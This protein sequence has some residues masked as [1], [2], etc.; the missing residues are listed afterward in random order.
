[1]HI[2]VT[3]NLLKVYQLL[4]VL[5][6]LGAWIDTTFRSWVTNAFCPRT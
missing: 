6:F 4:I 1:M 2:G 3:N 5:R